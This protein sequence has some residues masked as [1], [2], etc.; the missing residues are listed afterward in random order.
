MF[1][2]EELIFRAFRENRELA[3]YSW[4]CKSLVDLRDRELKA[5]QIVRSQNM[6]IQERLVMSM[7]MEDVLDDDEN[8][9]LDEVDEQEEEGKNCKVCKTLVYLSWIASSCC[10]EVVCLEHMDQV[11]FR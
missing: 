8:V 9:I 4:F 10:T 1:S 3:A 6:L 5:R 11:Y 7:V 2:H